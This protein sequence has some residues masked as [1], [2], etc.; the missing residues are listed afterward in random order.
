MWFRQIEDRQLAQYAYLIGCQQ[1]GEAIVVDPMRHVDA[2]VEM[3]QREGLSLVAAAETHIHA[4]YLSGLR[5]LAER[6]ITV[7]ASRDGGPDWQYEWLRGSSY[8]HRLLSHG[9][10]FSIGNIHFEAVHTPGHTPEHIC[11][12]VTDGGGSATSP[13]GIL[14]GDFV[15]VGAVGRPDLLE[16]AAGE[17]GAMEPAARELYRSIET[18]R[19]L[20]DHLQLWPAHGSG[21][22][23]GKGLGA[24][25]MS[26]VGYEKSFNES[27]QQAGDEDG[28]VQ[29]ILDGQQEPPLYFGRMKVHNRV[30]PAVLGNLP[31]PRL[32]HQGKLEELCGAVGVAVLD[33]R[34]WDAYRS[35]HLP[36]ALYAPLNK[37]F[38]TIVG[39][40][41]PEDMA[42]YLI[43]DE[44]DLRGAVVDLVHV[45]LDR[46]INYATP[47]MFAEYVGSGGKVMR[48]GE[49][50]PEELE[51]IPAGAFVLD[52]RGAAELAETGAIAGAHQIAWTR[53]LERLDEVPKKEPV[54]V[55]CETG[56]RSSYACGL[57]ARMSRNVT[58]VAGGL[59][60]WQASGGEVANVGAGS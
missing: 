30:G 17:Q 59:V 49:K 43:V 20:P 24:V 34:G 45:G 23:C 40:Y 26:T 9:D 16:S 46:V 32:M 18:F 33:T 56:S 44:A 5:E 41:V 3:A 6:G 55:Y 14:T 2:Y 38:N 47:D 42:I 35:A 28:F 29:Y 31:Q 19:Q 53:L 22:A 12:L 8:P 52:V 13:M 50:A 25:P 60:A 7:Y 10:R 39:C 58:N 51:E 4:D 54:L 11:F 57:L 21:S 27:I 15:F 37:A 48:V 36:G 1:T